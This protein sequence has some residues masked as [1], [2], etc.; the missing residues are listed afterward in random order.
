MS[1]GKAYGMTFFG[2]P[3]SGKDIPEDEIPGRL[4]FGRTPAHGPRA[5]VYV[6]QI[7][8]HSTGLVI[9]MECRTPGVEADLQQMV[10]GAFRIGVR[11]GGPAPVIVE[12]RAAGRGDARSI[13]YWATPL[14]A[15][16]EWHLFARWPDQGIDHC[17]WHIPAAAFEAAKQEIRP[18][19]G[20]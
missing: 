14:P 2:E 1:S 15:P 16:G 11:A 8:V 13:G 17:E 20:A 7:N 4:L 18:L 5:A 3:P 6:D 10:R 19:W 12:Y 9:H